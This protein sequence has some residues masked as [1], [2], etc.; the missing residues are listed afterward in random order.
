MAYSTPS[1]QSMRCWC[2]APQILVGGSYTVELS[3]TK[4]FTPLDR[5]KSTNSMTGLCASSEYIMLMTRKTAL[6]GLLFSLAL[7]MGIS[8]VLAS[9]K[10]KRAE[11]FS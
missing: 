6:T 5:A 4:R 2:T 1:P 11:D 7:L 3:S 8:Y 10:S 9:S